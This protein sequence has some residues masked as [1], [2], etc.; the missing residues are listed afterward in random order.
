MTSA[1]AL[2]ERKIGQQTVEIEFLKSLAT[3]QGAT[4]TRHRQWRQRLYQQIREAVQAEAAV[5]R[6]CE[7]AGVSRAAITVSFSERKPRKPI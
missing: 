7:A 3:F 4:P 5:N 6:L 1:I 2:L